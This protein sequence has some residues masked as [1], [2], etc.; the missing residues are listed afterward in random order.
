MVQ[1]HALIATRKYSRI[2]GLTLPMRGAEKAV[3]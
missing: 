3:I 2:L 1:F